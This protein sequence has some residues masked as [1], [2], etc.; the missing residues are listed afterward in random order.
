[1]TQTDRQSDRDSASSKYCVLSIFT[2][3]FLHLHVHVCVHVTTCVCTCILNNTCTQNVQYAVLC[4]Y[5]P[6]VL[7]SLFLTMSR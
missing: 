3:N 1:M 2:D 4:C 5:L 6:P 7:N